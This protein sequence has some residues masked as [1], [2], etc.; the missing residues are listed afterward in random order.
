MY[1][2]MPH[3]HGLFWYFLLHRIQTSIFADLSGTGWQLCQS[4]TVPCLSQGQNSHWLQQCNSRS[5]TCKQPVFCVDS[6]NGSMPEAWFWC[7]FLCSAATGG[8]VRI[9]GCSPDLKLWYPCSLNLPH[10]GAWA[11]AQ[12][13]SCL[14]SL[15]AASQTQPCGDFLEPNLS[16]Q[17]HGQRK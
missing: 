15:L 3:Q 14:P 4:E 11:W 2:F 8:R 10:S 9:C 1:G 16:R 17:L 5:K 7:C 13:F 6:A 12:I